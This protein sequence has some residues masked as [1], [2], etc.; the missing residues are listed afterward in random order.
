M[1]KEEWITLCYEQYIKRGCDQHKARLWAES[2][3]NRINN[4]LSKNPIIEADNDL[5]S[6][7][8]T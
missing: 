7:S 1:S 3:Y 2:T 6:W 4:P 8:D 5:A